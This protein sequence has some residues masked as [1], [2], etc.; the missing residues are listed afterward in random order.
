MQS[1]KIKIKIRLVGQFPANNLVDTGRKLNVLCKFSLRP[2][3]TGKFMLQFNNRSTPKRCGICLK[4]T[5]RAP[6]QRQ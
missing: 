4:L 6:K 5:I 1:V 3:S 2:V